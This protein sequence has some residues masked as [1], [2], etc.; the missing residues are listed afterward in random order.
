VSTHQTR[1]SEPTEGQQ[2]KKKQHPRRAI[3]E[4][5]GVE[6]FVNLPDQVLNCLFQTPWVPPALRVYF[7]LIRKSWGYGLTY[8]IYGLSKTEWG[9]VAPD[10]LKQTHI[11]QDCGFPTEY[12]EA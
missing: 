9:H 11:A 8:A 1:T 12:G 7:Y 2:K 10:P 3:M 6:Y 5:L 4:A